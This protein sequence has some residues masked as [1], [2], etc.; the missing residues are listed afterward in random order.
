MMN[1]TDSRLSPSFH[2]IFL[3]LTLLGVPLNAQEQASTNHSNTVE[4]CQSEAEKVHNDFKNA[5]KKIQA[6]PSLL[7][8]GEAEKVFYEFQKA[9][10]AIKSETEQKLEIVNKEIDRIKNTELPEKDKNALTSAL[11]ENIHKLQRIKESLNKSIAYSSQSK[12]EEWKKIYANWLGVSGPDKAK[13]RISSEIDSFFKE[14]PDIAKP[15]SIS[16]NIQG[17]GGYFSS[18]F[19]DFVVLPRWAWISLVS[20]V[21]IGTTLCIITRSDM[22]IGGTVVLTG[23]ILV[24]WLINLLWRAVLA[25]F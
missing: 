21:L 11:S 23:L 15:S 7:D 1:Q 13:Q 19:Q 10:S 3:A 18:R 12:P 2:Q 20:V 5:L 22:I 17:V 9:C 8:T 4:F 6:I 25:L 14:L 24:F 16:S